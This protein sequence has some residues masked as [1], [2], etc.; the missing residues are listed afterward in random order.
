MQGKALVL[1]LHVFV[2]LLSPQADV[3]TQGIAHGGM[4]QCKVT[5][6]SRNYR[7]MDFRDCYHFFGSCRQMGS[8]SAIDKKYVGAVISALPTHQN[9]DLR[10]VASAVPGIAP[11]INNKT[12]KH[13]NEKRLN[14]I[15]KNGQTP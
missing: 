4:K 10:Y 8:Y 7:Y 12:A 3:T 6:N 2:W 5:T 11:S 1:A 15:I 14:T 13:H 9:S